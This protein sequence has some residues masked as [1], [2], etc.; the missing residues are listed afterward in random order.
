MGSL[1]RLL[2]T[3]HLCVSAAHGA[4]HAMLGIWPCAADAA[5]IAAAVYA[6]PAAA[7]LFARR[8]AAGFLL[9]ASMAGSLAFG[10]HHHFLAVSPD[11]LSLLPP[12]GW[13]AAFRATAVGSL[14]VDAAALFAALWRK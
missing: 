9:A 8:P 1:A 13:G 6:A 14:P 3:M 11:H 2:A 5:F 7:I 4:C 10:V 12:G